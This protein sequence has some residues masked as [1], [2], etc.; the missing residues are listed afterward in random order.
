VILDAKHSSK[1]NANAIENFL[2]CLGIQILVLIAD[3]WKPYQN[4]AITLGAE[5]QLC[6][7]HAKK[8]ANKHFKEALEE[9]PELCE[10]LKQLLNQML[11]LDLEIS[12]KLLNET[13]AIL[14]EMHDETAKW[15]L[16]F[17]RNYGERLL[18]KKTNNAAETI[19]SLFEQL[20]DNMKCFKNGESADLFLKAFA[21]HHNFKIF[22]RGKRKGRCPLE[23]EGFELSS[24]D[25]LDYIGFSRSRIASTLK[26]KAKVEIS[27]TSTTRE[28]GITIM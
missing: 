19:F 13:I 25:W 28:I 23:L 10:V 22:K 20:Y 18:P 16:K 11:S 4:A 1:R 8:A 9:N 27:I 6:I 17:L 7:V 26:M 12:K 24:N 21:V 15:F 5:L 14:E 3:L 2:L